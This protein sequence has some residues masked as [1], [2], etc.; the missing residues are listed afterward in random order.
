MQLPMTFSAA[1]SESQNTE[2]LFFVD[3]KLAVTG[4]EKRLRKVA[5]LTLQLPD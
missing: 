5:I 1:L 3:M 4:K 2:Q